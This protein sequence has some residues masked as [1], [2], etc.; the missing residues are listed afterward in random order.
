MWAEIDT[1]KSLLMLNKIS[2]WW[3]LKWLSALIIS[4]LQLDG[5]RVFLGFFLPCFPFS[6]HFVFSFLLFFLPTFSLLLICFS[7]LLCFLSFCPP[8]LPF[9][10]FF[11]FL[12]FP[13]LL[14]SLLSSASLLSLTFSPDF[15]LFLPYFLSFPSLLSL[16]FFTT[17]S[18]LLRSFLSFSHYSVLSANTIA[19]SLMQR[20][21]SGTV[22]A[23]EE[24]TIRSRRE[25]LRCSL[26]RYQWATH[27]YRYAVK[28]Q[29][30]FQSN[31][32]VASPVWCNPVPY[33]NFTLWSKT[34]GWP[35]TTKPD[36]LWKL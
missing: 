36:F 2:I 1:Y 34:V 32:V 15:Y 17:F 35:T 11:F 30:D 6:L 33:S 12:S 24:A 28:L 25:L 8:Y 5:K 31:F 19:D 16:F 27:L 23:L 26:V 21:A 20:P 10:L 7:L 4:K 18:L 29:I 3:K 14:P 9:F 22:L 13:L